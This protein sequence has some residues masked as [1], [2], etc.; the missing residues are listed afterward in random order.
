[1]SQD[2]DLVFNW[3]KANVLLTVLAAKS[4]RGGGA[5]PSRSHEEWNNLHSMA[6]TQ[7]TDCSK[8]YDS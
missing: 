4:D 1:M 5:F 3:A 8:R 6:T 7:W 2:L